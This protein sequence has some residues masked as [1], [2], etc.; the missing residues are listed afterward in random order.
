MDYLVLK[1]RRGNA[2]AGFAGRGAE[3]QAKPSRALAPGKR[4]L[5]FLGG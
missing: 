5:K 3:M 4:S 1:E 2:G